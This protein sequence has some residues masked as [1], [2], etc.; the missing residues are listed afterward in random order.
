MV[1]SRRKVE[2]SP[3]ENSWEVL[4]VAV[5]VYLWTDER[6]CLLADE[7]C[8]LFFVHAYSPQMF[9]CW[10][11]AA[12]SSVQ[13]L[14]PIRA[15]IGEMLA[16]EASNLA[17]RNYKRSTTLRQ[18]IEQP[19]QIIKQ[20]LTGQDFRLQIYYLTYRLTYHDLDLGQRQAS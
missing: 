13:N 8:L 18:S 11:S 1:G 10:R 15:P 3:T 19:G 14:Q 12:L 5:A 9:A 4:F 7:E 16:K 20:M 2:D 6:C 17:G